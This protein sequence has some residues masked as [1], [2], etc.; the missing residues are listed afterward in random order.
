MFKVILR[1]ISAT[2]LTAALITPSKAGEAEKL[3]EVFVTVDGTRG[4]A[5]YVMPGD[6]VDIKVNQFIDGKV[7]NAVILEDI[8]VIATEPVDRYGLLLL[9]TLRLN[10]AQAKEL[11]V[12][13]TVGTISFELRQLWGD[14][15]RDGIVIYPDCWEE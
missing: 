8:E 12:A 1:T 9:A 14:S 3:R 2:V 11:A 13:K 5:A 7:A 4:V 10:E 6:R 15:C